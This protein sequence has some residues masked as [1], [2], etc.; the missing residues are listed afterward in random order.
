MESSDSEGIVCASHSAVQLLLVRS[1][2][3]SSIFLEESN[4]LSQTT[5]QL[6]LLQDDF[7]NSSLSA[8][9][10]AYSQSNDCFLY[11]DKTKNETDFKPYLS[12]GNELSSSSLL[13]PR[14]TSSLI[15][16]KLSYI[17]NDKLP[18]QHPLFSNE[19]TSWPEFFQFL[20]LGR[21]CP[22]FVR[23]L[24]AGTGI[25]LVDRAVSDG[26]VHL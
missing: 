4:S 22:F 5:T 16:A 3:S 13:R 25:Y 18:T 14:R 20:I 6:D 2:S 11:Q 19:L 10:S 15:L 7:G 12:L 21:I 24:A 26:L 23:G 8:S 1:E 17:E 9:I